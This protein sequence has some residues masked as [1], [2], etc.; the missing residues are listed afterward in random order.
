MQAFKA[1]VT[2]PEDRMVKLPDEV[3]TGPAEVI[4]LREPTHDAR[5]QRLREFLTYVDEARAR[6]Q[7]TLTKDEIDRY[8]EEER[9]SW[10]E[11]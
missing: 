11:A 2:V 10:G 6:L 1:A 8:I 7:P 9:K 5:S 3:P 4:V